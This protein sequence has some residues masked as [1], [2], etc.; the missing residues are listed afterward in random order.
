MRNDSVRDILRFMDTLLYPDAPP[1]YVVYDGACT[2][3]LS[4]KQGNLLEDYGDRWY[5]NP[6][7][8][9][10][11]VDRFQF[12]GHSAEDDHCKYG[13]RLRITALPQLTRI[14]GLVHVIHKH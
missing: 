4:F 10:W 3:T 9:S 2:L 11:R 5:W 8:P 13:I 1:D 14:H 6:E 12:L 7:A